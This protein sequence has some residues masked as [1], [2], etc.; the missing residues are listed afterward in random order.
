MRLGLLKGSSFSLSEG[1]E[2]SGTV[3][4]DSW[5]ASEKAAKEKAGDGPSAAK[6]LRYQTAQSHR[7]RET[8]QVQQTAASADNDAHL[9]P[10]NGLSKCVPSP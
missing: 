5:T 9:H 2:T 7:V 1:K 3:A 10:H 4:V 6:R 8:H